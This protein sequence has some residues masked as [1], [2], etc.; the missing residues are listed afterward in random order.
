MPRLRIGVNAL[1]LIPG[2]V[3]GTEIYLRSLL[4]ALAE[5]DS[6]NEYIL[7]INRETG[8][9]LA[10]DAPNFTLAPQ[11]VRAAVRPAR[12]LWEQLALP[13]AAR[14]HRLSVL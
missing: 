13:V 10:P 12:I 4:H 5:I 7:F 6:R 11:S 14:Y 3:G 8:L 1:Y 2:G 9:D